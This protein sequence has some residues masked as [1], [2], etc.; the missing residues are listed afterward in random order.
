MLSLCIIAK[1]EEA[2]LDDCL[3]SVNGLVD[4]IIV[5][6]TGSTDKTKEIAKKHGAKIFD[7]S[8]ND[9]FSAARNEAISHAK[10]DWIL[11]LDAD[12]GVAKTSH[13]QIRE[14]I[15]D[16]E[17]W[18]FRVPI[19]N[20]SN[21]STI[22][23]WSA[24]KEPVKGFSGFI[25]TRVIRLF[26]NKPEIKY[27]FTIHE[28]VEFAIEENKGIAKIAPFIIHHYGALRKNAS[29]EAKQETYFMLV[30]KDCEKYPSHPKPFY[31]LGVG[32][33]DLGQWDLAKQA[34]EKA[35]I[36][37]EKYL[38]PY[39]QLGEIVYVQGN[40]AEAKKMFEKSISIHPTE[41]T[42]FRLGQID[43]RLNDP[44][45][46]KSNWRKALEMNPASIKYYDALIQ[47]H[48]LVK[49]PLMALALLYDVCSNTN[50]PHFVEQKKNV[51]EQII[52]ESKKVLADGPEKKCLISLITIAF[53]R[54]EKKKVIGLC[55]EAKK[56]FVG[57]E[58]NVFDVFIERAKN[59]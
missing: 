58:G 20:Y 59:M 17:A 28:G 39:F 47:L 34:F 45:S 3:S 31:E 21:N 11:A 40:F 55:E 44:E 18:G 5:V 38:L 23:G 52:Q 42:Y 27:K 53:Y 25:L 46:A 49:E 41:E 56:H 54:K 50:H 57:A 30:K 29:S 12:E 4:E 48:L 36:N 26:R 19:F 9:D 16:K 22:A 35:I 51:E 8:W 6:D 32:Y 33:I 2:F 37:N 1:D 7:F 14:C 24:V 43:L 15:K 10:G 13:E